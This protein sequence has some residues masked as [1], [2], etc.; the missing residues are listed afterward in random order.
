MNFY[1][2]SKANWQSRQFNDNL[3]TCLFSLKFNSL[4]PFEKTDFVT[5][6]SKEYRVMLRMNFP[7]LVS[8]IYFII[9]LW[10]PLFGFFCVIKKI[11]A[12]SVGSFSLLTHA[13]TCL[14]RQHWKKQLEYCDSVV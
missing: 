13:L 6:W 8:E 4:A 14:S 1:Q 5:S 9:S 2:P 7:K 12:F 3:M 10:N 11:F